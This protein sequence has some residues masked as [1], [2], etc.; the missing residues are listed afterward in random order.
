MSDPGRAVAIRPDA[1]PGFDPDTLI[2]CKTP[3]ERAILNAGIN[4]YAREED[5]ADA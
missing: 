4:K 3:E 5:A 1:L 2:L